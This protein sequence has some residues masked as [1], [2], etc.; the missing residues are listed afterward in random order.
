MDTIRERL[1]LLNQSLTRADG[2]VIVSDTRE[3]VS[4]ARSI[5]TAAPVAW[6]GRRGPALHSTQ[7]AGD[8]EAASSL[9]ADFVL[10]AIADE[11]IR[12][13]D[14]SLSG[15]AESLSGRT[16]LSARRSRA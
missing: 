6:P 2:V 11:L 9:M 16:T 13:G 3:A 7:I 10:M 5:I 1:V 12:V 14:S 8:L 15:C 4:V